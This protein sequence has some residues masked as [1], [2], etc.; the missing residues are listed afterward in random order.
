[1]FLLKLEFFDFSEGGEN[2]FDVIFGETE[3]DI[4]NI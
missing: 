4:A 3:V 2:F 1:M